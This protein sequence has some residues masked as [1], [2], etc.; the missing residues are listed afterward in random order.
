M[1]R[2]GVDGECV[3]V[4]SLEKERPEV[5]GCAP[6]LASSAGPVWSLRHFCA[7][8]SRARGWGVGKRRENAKRK[9][10]RINNPTARLSLSL[11]L[12]LSLCLISRVTGAQRRRGCA[13]RWSPTDDGGWSGWM[14]GRREGWREAR[15]LLENQLLGGHPQQHTTRTHTHTHTHT[16]TNTL[17]ADGRRMRAALSVLQSEKGLLSHPSFISVL[18]SF[19]SPLAGMPHTPTPIPTRRQRWSWRRG[20]RGRLKGW[21]MRGN[22]RA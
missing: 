5:G 12:S 8:S 19:C 1:G 9:A 21:E 2:V 22:G 10:R 11:S 13:G 6:Y 7:R 3:C 20:R 4:L 15:Q 14:D 17:L 18:H 16:H